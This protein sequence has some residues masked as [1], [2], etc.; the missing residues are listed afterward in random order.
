MKVSEAWHESATWICC[1]GVAVFPSTLF[2]SVLCSCVLLMLLYSLCLSLFCMCMYVCVY[3]Y[4]FLLL[5]HGIE[6][7]SRFLV[8]DGQFCGFTQ[9]RQIVSVVGS[10]GALWKT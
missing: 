6:H 1:F 2:K 10:A 3:V 9:N 5:C 7:T 4:V 8:V